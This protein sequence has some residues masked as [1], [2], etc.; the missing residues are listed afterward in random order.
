MNNDKPE[1]NNPKPTT[2]QP[3]KK[4]FDVVRP[5]KAPASPN[6]RSVIVG[7][8]PQVADDQFV[9]GPNTRLA[10]DPSEKR[11]L[12]D[13]DKKVGVTPL[14]DKVEP[15]EP[16][17]AQ[18]SE[19]EAKHEE[20]S[21]ISTAPP[22]QPEQTPTE[23]E[24]E[25][26]AAEL[27]PM[28]DPVDKTLD[29]TKEVSAPEIPPATKPNEPKQ[30]LEHLAVGQVVDVKEDID[31]EPPE[32]AKS[33]EGFTKP[34]TQE[35]VVANTDAPVLEHAVVSHHKHHT[36]LWEWLLIFFLIVLL[37]VVAV[38][39]LLDAEVVTTGLDIPHTD[40]FKN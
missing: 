34:M 14:S 39:F 27:L 7:H 3:G 30:T 26:K 40:L 2:F 23:A 18:A 24:I 15:A 5:G 21:D 25:E 32:S 35:D 13:P 12:M 6:S 36:K 37:A 10:S 38:N 28:S 22:L 9:P 8:K 11:P 31:P 1:D 29:E 19:Q 16:S 33:N 20:E 17:V 4:V